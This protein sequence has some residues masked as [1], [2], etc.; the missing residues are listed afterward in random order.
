MRPTFDINFTAA[1]LELLLET[2]A[3]AACRKESQ[4]RAVKHGRHHDLA[5]VKMRLL[6]ARLSMRLRGVR[7]RAAA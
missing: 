5:A 4:A 7:M 1:E 2:L 6:R 3:M